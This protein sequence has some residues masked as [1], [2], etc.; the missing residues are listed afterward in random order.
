MFVLLLVGLPGLALAEWYVAGYGGLSATS[1]L[2]DVKQDNYGQ[3]LGFRQFPGA[4]A[5]PPLGTLIQSFK[6]SDVS[7]KHSPLFGGKV[8]YFFKEEGLSW[9]GV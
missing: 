6:T 2:T 7:L 5:P 3:Q 4:T 9:L 1:S 8:G